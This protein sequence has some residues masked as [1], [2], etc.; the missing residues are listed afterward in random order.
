MKS[1]S[2]RGAM[3]LG[4]V[5]LTMTAV[6]L[7]VVAFTFFNAEAPVPDRPTLTLPRVIVSEVGMQPFELS[8]NVVGRVSPWQEVSLAPEV[9]GRVEE[10]RVDIGDRVAAD[11]V[12][13]TVDRDSYETAL[14]EAEAN[15]LRAQA[16]LEESDAA[17]TR[18][19]SLRERGAISEREY[20]AALAQKRASDADLRLAEAGLA[21]ARRDLRDTEL[22][23]P[24]AGTIVERHVDP[25][26]LV[27]RDRAVLVLADMDIVAVEVGLTET[28]ILQ[29]RD[30]EIAFVESSSLPGRVAQ[31]TIDGL[32]ERADPA[33]GTYLV[34]IKV[35]N[36]DESRFLGGMV[37]D[38]RIPYKELDAIPT[39]P[40]AAVL[41]PGEAPHVFIIRDGRVRRVDLEI[42]ARDGGRIGVLPRAHGANGPASSAA[43]NG[44]SAE[45]GLGDLVVVVGQS[46]LADGAEVE[47]AAQR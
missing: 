27:G 28:E 40:A 37:V 22:R 16:R 35:D 19:Q 15:E 9:S 14:L 3:R 18:S 32:A 23:A 6:L 34:R 20:E 24:F 5:L 29:V 43:A 7:M 13:L 12:V 33:T 30:A 11:D 8:V 31:G 41:Q 42:V 47:V 10:I 1:A 21:R 2:E 39:V 17:L 26:A 45:L 44:D 38:A 4:Q 46:Q 25:G 36:R